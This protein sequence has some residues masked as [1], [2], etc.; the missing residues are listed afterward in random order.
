MDVED[1]GSK[2]QDSMID[3]GYDAALSN[4]ITGSA[5]HSDRHGNGPAPRLR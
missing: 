4:G 2:G 3:V 5:G 1:R